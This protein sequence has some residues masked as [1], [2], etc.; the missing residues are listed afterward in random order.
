VIDVSPTPEP[1]A[2]FHTREELTT[3]Q[4]G[5]FRSLLYDDFP[6]LQQPFDSPHVSQEWD[7]PIQTIGDPMRR[8][9]LSSLSLAKRVELNRQLKDA[10]EAGLIRPNHSE[11]GSPFFF[12]A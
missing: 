10:M 3:K 8:H 6:E 12:C 11:I 7:H 1:L 9:R 5:N 2:E 4:R